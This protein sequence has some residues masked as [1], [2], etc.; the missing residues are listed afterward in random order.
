MIVNGVTPEQMRES[1]FIA[2]IAQVLFLM[3][4]DGIPS[5]DEGFAK[6]VAEWCDLHGL[7]DPA[8]VDAALR[9]I[10]EYRASVL[11]LVYVP[12]IDTTPAE[13]CR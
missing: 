10:E 2:V 7:E 5:D 8:E 12:E 13:A 11:P 3:R 6:A 9:V 4:D 1:K